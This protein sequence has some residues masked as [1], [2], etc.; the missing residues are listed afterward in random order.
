MA[1]KISKI[2]C[3][4]SEVTE[5]LLPKIKNSEIDSA[6]KDNGLVINNFLKKLLD[7]S[8]KKSGSTNKNS[9]DKATKKFSIYLYY[10]GERLL[11]ETLHANLPNALPSI[12]TLN[13]Y[14]YVDILRKVK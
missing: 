8:L 11:Y 7:I 5:N 12:S 4:N 9:Y 2:I 3:H 6:I 14:M 13:R 1:E 10:V